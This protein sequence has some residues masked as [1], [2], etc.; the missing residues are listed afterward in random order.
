[1]TLLISH[2]TIKIIKFIQKCL[3]GKKEAKQAV[4]VGFNPNMGFIS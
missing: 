1:M 3:L 4:P 2:T